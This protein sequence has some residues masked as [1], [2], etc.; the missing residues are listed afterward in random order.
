MFSLAVTEYF[1]SNFGT[2]ISSSLKMTRVSQAR[3][4]QGISSKVGKV[5][6]VV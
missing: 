5:G 6:T 4:G 2:F 1:S 3:L